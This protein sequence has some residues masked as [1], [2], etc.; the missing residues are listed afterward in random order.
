ML[1]RKIGFIL[2]FAGVALGVL[3]IVL[4][5]STRPKEIGHLA[6][7]SFTNTA[8]KS[9]RPSQSDIE[10][11]SVP[12]THPKFIGI[13]AIEVPKSK[14]LEY[15]LGQNRT[16]ISP[17]SSYD[18]GWYDGSSKPGQQGAMFI[19]GH[20]AGPSGGG[21][22]YN[23]KGLKTGDEIVI[24]R[25][26]DKT[27]TYQVVSARTYPYD[28]VDMSVVLSPVEPGVPGLNLMTC[29]GKIIPDSNPV[30]FEQR[31]VVFTK[32]VKSD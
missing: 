32:L 21:I 19:Y 7:P 1:K 25:G 10:S 9:D 31:L 20:V 17:D 23:L 27:Y 18:T 5:Y 3:V 15:G 26:D 11:Y 28:S 2:I 24:T 12:P 29:T 4:A 14:V 6:P 30:N 8:G 16:I 13:S 22:F